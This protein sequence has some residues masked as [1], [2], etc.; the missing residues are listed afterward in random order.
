[1]PSLVSLYYFNDSGSRVA[2]VSNIETEP[3]SNPLVLRDVPVLLSTRLQT[4]V[5]FSKPHGVDFSAR[6]V[7]QV[8][9][10]GDVNIGQTRSCC[11]AALKPTFRKE[12]SAVCANISDYLA[13]SEYMKLRH[14]VSSTAYIPLSR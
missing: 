7:A 5:Q 4:V 1:M 11:S 6:S 13:Q 9:E 8:G 3:M 10:R 14:Y 2:E 12:Y